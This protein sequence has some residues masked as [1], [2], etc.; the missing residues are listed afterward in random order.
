MSKYFRA[1]VFFI[2]QSIPNTI[3][4]KNNITANYLKYT[5]HTTQKQIKLKEDKK[6]R[7]LHD[8]I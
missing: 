4:Q 2:Y 3:L 8:C 7:T 5:Y 6:Q 1:S